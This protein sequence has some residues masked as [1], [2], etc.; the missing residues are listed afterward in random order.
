MKD[1]SEEFGTNLVVLWMVLL[2]DDGI[3]QII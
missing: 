1:W 3:K 2:C